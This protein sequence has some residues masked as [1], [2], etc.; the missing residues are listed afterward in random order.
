MRESERCKICA[1]NNP[2]EAVVKSF[3]CR[4]YVD[5]F[6]QASYLFVTHFHESNSKQLHFYHVG[7]L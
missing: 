1:N 4:F 2:R 3:L 6:M 7:M 5:D